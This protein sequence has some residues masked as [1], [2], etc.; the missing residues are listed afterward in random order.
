MSNKK[1]ISCAANYVSKHRARILV[2]SISWASALYI[3][4]VQRLNVIAQAAAF[5]FA[6]RICSFSPCIEQ[7]QNVCRALELAGFTD[8]QVRCPGWMM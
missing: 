1:V 8:L 6:C 7:I 5:V 3:S 2:A 4:I